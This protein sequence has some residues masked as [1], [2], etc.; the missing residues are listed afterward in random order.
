MNFRSYVR[1][2]KVNF[3]LYLFVLPA[4]VMIFLFS[5]VPMYGV[6][7]A[8]KHFVPIQ[9]ILGSD[10]VGIQYF[11]RFFHSYQFT[12]LIKNTVGTS[13]YLLAVSFPLPIIIA[14]VFN[15][16]TKKRFKTIIQTVSYA[17]HFISTVVIVGMM[18]VF[19]SP[20]SGIINNLREA[21]GYSTINYMGE[22]GWYKTLYVLSD[23]WQHTGWD[24]IIYIAALSSIDSQ[25]YDAAD[26]DGASKW[27]R[28]WHIEI[29]SLV[30]TIIIILI[31]KT[32]GVIGVGF[33][34]A[35]LMQNSLNIS[36]SEVIETYVYKIGLQSL[37]YSYSAAIGLFTNVINFVIL[38]SVNQI[39]RRSG[40]SGLW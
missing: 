9:G 1:N 39:A 26:I 14:L 24:A 5:Y 34:K 6:Q 29:P 18:L 10:W 37:Q 11:E 20:S 13:L 40:N 35:Y 22:P 21:F 31:L 3:D 17:P 12:N 25:L 4:V 7:I 36:S 33:E 19:L 2:V 8:F 16:I 23:V 15:Q 28:I 30:P 32:G 27:R 38:V